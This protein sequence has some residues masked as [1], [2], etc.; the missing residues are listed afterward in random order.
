MKYQ[1]NRSSKNSKIFGKDAQCRH[2]D[3]HVV[4]ARLLV[5]NSHKVSEFR[6]FAPICNQC[7]STL[8]CG[9]SNFG[10]CEVYTISVVGDLRQI[11]VFL[12]YLQFPPLI[13]LTT[14]IF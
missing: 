12:A 11:G 7:L 9:M 6:C 5:P 4:G 1:N 8:Q 14:M 10:P 13:K 2:S 3:S